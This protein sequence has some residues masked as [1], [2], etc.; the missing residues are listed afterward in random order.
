MLLFDAVSPYMRL[1]A[2]LFPCYAFVKAN[3]SV[4]ESVGAARKKN[5]G[6]Q[7]KEGHNPGATGG[8]DRN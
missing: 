3:G 6:Y 5:S 2:Q 8:E 4:N 1:Q 7:G